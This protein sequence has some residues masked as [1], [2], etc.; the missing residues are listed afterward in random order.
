MTVWFTSDLHLGHRAVAYDRRYGGWPK[1]R[2]LVTPED[3]EW[4]DTML[5]DK[6]DAVVGKDDVVWGLGDLIA[7]PKSLP[8][9]L[10]WIDKRPGRKHWILG[11]HDPAHPLHSESEKWE[12]RY[13]EVFESVG[14]VR[15]RTIT[16]PGGAKQTALLSHFPYRG[17]GDGREDRC[18]QFR[19]R[20]KGLPI[21]HGHTHSKER[22]TT[23]DHQEPDH[24]EDQ[25]GL[26]AP[27]MQV[28]V[29]VDAWNF[30][31]VSLE[32]IAELL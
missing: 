13:H 1:D 26:Y 6:W 10:E 14:I 29:G 4:H 8:A 27:A 15:R 9:A 21:L 28:H 22:I 18:D 31:P 20:D 7:N 32:Q 17:D 12:K 19:L 23:S 3:V 16:L 5:A 11:N 30:A 24:R 2:S 25:D